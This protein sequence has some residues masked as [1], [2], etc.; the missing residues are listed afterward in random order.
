VKELP[1]WI[2][3]NLECGKE[4][5]DKD[6]SLDACKIC[7]TKRSAKSLLIRKT[8]LEG[9]KTRD[10]ET[11]KRLKSY[12]AKCGLEKRKRN[13]A[14]R[15]ELLASV[16]DKGG[17]CM[18]CKDQP[19]KEIDH[20]R[21]ELKT[22]CFGNRPSI[23]KM[24]EEIAR[25]T[26]NG[27]VHLQGVC[28]ECH[29]LKSK[30]QNK[31]LNEARAKRYPKLTFAMEYIQNCKIER[32]HCVYEHCLRKDSLCT[33]SNVSSFEFDHFHSTQCKCDE[34]EANPELRKRFKISDYA[35]KVPAGETKEIMR[36]ELDTEM[37]KCRM[38]H[39]ECHL[40]HTSEQL[41]KNH[42]VNKQKAEEAEATKEAAVLVKPMAAAVT[43]PPQKK[44][45]AKAETS[46]SVEPSQ[47]KQRRS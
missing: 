23:K 21:P 2:C 19:A 34:C 39:R 25:N 36:K 18:I 33:L 10:P 16:S 24:K 47:K 44:R 41:R 17:K 27:K 8:K 45:K 38:L 1:G 4:H 14:F 32:K 9:S 6:C 11:W 30:K 37:A 13:R 12:D 7:K 3:E 31:E 46:E 22:L 28:C 5:R 40:K 43:K 20:I 42:Q 26:V 35:R 29:V 15:A